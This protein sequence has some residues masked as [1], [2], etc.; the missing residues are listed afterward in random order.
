MVNDNLTWKK[1]IDQL[2]SKLNSACYAIRAVNVTLSRELLRMLYF[3]YVHSIM[4]YGIIVLKYSG[5]K[6]KF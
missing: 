4:S 2:I 3:L 5:Y 6:I 1:H